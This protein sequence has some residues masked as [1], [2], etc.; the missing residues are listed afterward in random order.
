MICCTGMVNP[1]G[2][3]ERAA[4]R[5]EVRLE[6]AAV[7]ADDAGLRRVARFT[8]G[9]VRTVEMRW[10][11]VKRA[12]A[13]RRDVLA[14]PV[15]CLAVTDASQVVVLDEAME[16]WGTLVKAFGRLAGATAFSEWL[17]EIRAGSDASGWAVL[18]RGDL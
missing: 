6:R 3:L 10:S 5:R 1:E 15:A 11:E 12:A 8:D 14:E 2:T 13:F 18:F 9:T 17:G 7:E 4:A 16:G